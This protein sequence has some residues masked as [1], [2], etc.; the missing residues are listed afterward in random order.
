MGNVSFTEMMLLDL[1]GEAPSA[2]HVRVID[3]ILVALMEH[4]TTPSTLASRLV[5]DGA[6]E[7]TQGA[8]AAGLLAV[9]SRFLGGIEGSAQLLQ[10]IVEGGG[11]E[12][13][14]RAQVREIVAAGRRVP[15]FGHNLHAREDPRV[16]KL[17]EIAR[18]QGV[19]K[20]H[21][22]AIAPLRAA[23]GSETGKA[24]IPNAAVAVGSVL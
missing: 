16:E 20:E 6:P 5:L 21:V 17:L 3:A 1:H 19:A 24:L 12:E 8:V 11:D 2:A 22:A 10:A 18:V 9:G 15:G 14:A 7:S 13:A 4:G 23:I